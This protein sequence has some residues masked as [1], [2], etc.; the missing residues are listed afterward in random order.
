MYVQ[1]RKPH[2]SA[3]GRSGGESG[4]RTLGEFD[5]TQHFEPFGLRPVSSPGVISES[6]KRRNLTVFN[7]FFGNLREICEKSA[8]N[9]VEQLAKSLDRISKGMFD[10]E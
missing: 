3:W 5:P 4:I 10:Y 8:R 2:A 6:S 9:I 7:A 1:K